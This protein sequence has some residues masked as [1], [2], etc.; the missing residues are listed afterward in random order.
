MDFVFARIFVSLV[1]GF[2]LIRC[3]SNFKA[4][5]SSEFWSDSFKVVHPVEEDAHLDEFQ[6]MIQNFM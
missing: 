1:Q 3:I 6:P 4:H 5:G 2:Y